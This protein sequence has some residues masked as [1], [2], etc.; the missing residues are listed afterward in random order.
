M[1]LFWSPL[2]DT[3]L[4]SSCS[5]WLMSAAIYTVNYNMY[6]QKDVYII[7]YT[8]GFLHC[9]ESPVHKMEY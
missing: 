1:L 2:A 6:R 7:W 4:A 5:Y 3:I 8:I 9:T